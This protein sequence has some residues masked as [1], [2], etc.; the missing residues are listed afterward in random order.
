V[1][2][3]GKVHTKLE[4][5]PEEAEVV[6]KIF[7]MFISGYSYSQ[8]ARKLNEEGYTNRG[9]PWKFS[10]ISEM[11]KNSRY[12]GR[13]F[14]GKGTKHQHRIVR[15]DAVVVNGP[16]IIDEKT[17]KKAQQ[18]MGGYTKRRP[19]KHNYFLTGIAFCECGA[20]LHGVFSRIPMYYCKHYREDSKQHVSIRA[21]KLEGFVL[22]YLENLVKDREIDFDMLARSINEVWSSSRPSQE[23]ITNSRKKK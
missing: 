15:E 12:A 5:N 1:K 9:K 6:K 10:A 4:V 23:E 17:W 2:V 19:T 18:R 3:D 21:R 13:H 16:R 14:W 8:I 11:L 20:P 7:E 22:G